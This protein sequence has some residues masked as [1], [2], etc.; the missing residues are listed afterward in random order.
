M[1]KVNFAVNVNWIMPWRDESQR[2][3]TR[4]DA[5]KWLYGLGMAACVGTYRF[6]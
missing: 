1:C 6:T 2:P 5:T 4:V 3:A